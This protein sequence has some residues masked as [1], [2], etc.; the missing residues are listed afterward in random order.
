MPESTP[1]EP[2]RGD[3]AGHLS[4]V[5]RLANSPSRVES[6]Q[7]GVNRSDANSAPAVLVGSS[8]SSTEPA[9]PQTSGF[10]ESDSYSVVPDSNEPKIGAQLRS[11]DISTGAS[12]SIVRPSANGNQTVGPAGSPHADGGTAA[13]SGA[14]SQPGED[15][16][17]SRRDTDPQ[18]ASQVARPA[19][20]D[21]GAE[22]HS[23]QAKA[24]LETSSEPLAADAALAGTRVDAM[25]HQAGSITPGVSEPEPRREG[26]PEPA[27]PPLMPNLQQLPHPA[28]TSQ[29]AIRLDTGNETGHVELRIRERGGEV[30]IAVRS[31]DPDTASSL[32]Q[33]LGDLVRRL[34]PRSN[35]SDPSRSE[36]LAD[37]AG[38]LSRH[39]PAEDSGSGYSPQDE[40]QH[41][42]DEQ[43]QHHH[44]QRQ[45]QEQREPSRTRQTSEGL[46]ELQNIINQLRNGAASS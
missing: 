33:D 13:D 38:Q 30:Q 3:D 34:D 7:A 11:S 5:V 44:H 4:F 10:I 40:G 31:T 2:A 27:P 1:A 9:I 25:V 16:T 15:S 37:A 24:T 19:S 22:S 6:L 41:R 17:S 46:E 20:F 32:R 14:D 12:R 26:Q 43:Q 8:S 42:Q 35:V 18:R 45:Q 28:A 39:G 36:G 23:R 29:I 21:A